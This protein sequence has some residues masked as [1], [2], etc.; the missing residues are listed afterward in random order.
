MPKRA[1][2]VNALGRVKADHPANLWDN[3]TQ[4]RGR[5]L[6]A[7]FLLVLTSQLIVDEV[8][9]MGFDDQPDGVPRCQLKSALSAASDVN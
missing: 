8:A 9:G 4:Q 6:S 7:L 1:A 3:L 5:K 2:I